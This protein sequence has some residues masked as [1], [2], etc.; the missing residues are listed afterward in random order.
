MTTDST[1]KWGPVAGPAIPSKPP[2]A[3]KIQRIP[4]LCTPFHLNMN[5]QTILRH[6]GSRLV[7]CI[8]GAA[9]ALSIALCLIGSLGSPFILAS[10]GGSTVFLFGL[11]RAPAT[12]PRA[13]FGGH[14]GTAAIGIACFQMFGTQT[15]VYV[16]A[17]VLA[18]CYMLGCRVT[19]PPAGANPI[20]MIS[21]HAGWATLLNPV[22]LGVGALAL[23]AVAWSRMYPGLVRYPLG[24]LAPSPATLLWGGW[25]DGVGESDPPGESGRNSR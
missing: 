2:F 11:T 22:L 5:L 1:P 23:T 10:L 19:H 6:P 14:L 7:W 17:Q 25:N 13:L 16:L 15:W 4:G 8:I 3:L 18:L 9:I 21:M 24:V 20:I 12:Q